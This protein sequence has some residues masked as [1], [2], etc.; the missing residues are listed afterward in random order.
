MT[1]QPLNGDV[2]AHDTLFRKDRA[3]HRYCIIKINLDYF[4]FSRFKMDL[5]W[6]DMRHDTEIHDVTGKALP[7]ISV[8]S[9][10]I[11]FLTDHLFQTLGD[12][13]HPMETSQILF[14]LTVPAIWTE[15]AKQ[16]MREAAVQAGIHT[17]QL[18][19]ALEPEAASLYCQRVPSQFMSCGTDDRINSPGTQY[20]VADIG[21]G[22][23][24]F[25]VHEVNEDGTLTEVHMATGG[26]YA[27]TN[28]DEEYIKLYNKIFG[29]KTMQKLKAMDMEEY[30]SISRNFET[31]KRLVCEEYSESFNV[32]L[33][34]ALFKRVKAKPRKMKK[35][36]AESGMKDLIS[37]DGDK[38]KFSP[39]AIK[40]LFCTPIDGIISHLQNLLQEHE[41]VKSILLVGGFSESKLLQEE[42]KKAMA[43]KTFVIPN[44]CGLAVLKGAVLYGHSPLSIT[45]R[46]MKY[47]YGVASDSIF[48]EGIHPKARKY[49]DENGEFRC[50]RS[51]SILI[52]KGTKVSATGVKIIRT[53]E[54]VTTTQMMIAERVYYT[55]NEN[56]IVVDE[57]CK[58]LKGYKL[59][60]PENN[61]KPRIV[62]STF[63][64]GLTEMKYCS[65]VIET[66]VQKVGTL[67]LL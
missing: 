6:K 41:K 22:T 49:K 66:G 5:H 45:S 31:K 60:L 59:S 52:S 26:P 15:S 56:P 27:G 1:S 38:I 23:A 47:T 8:F 48:K 13:G 25:S 62:K 9:S 63:T 16:F 10:S 40:R 46:I 61:G 43:D 57:K 21:G 55:D 67:D 18:V 19:L 37:I 4:F 42:I 28:V 64:F 34:A 2:I 7:A 17:N 20:L 24:D 29:W 3:Y 30:L 12:R 35:S 11:K 32:K 54:P 14:V 65:E 53:S 50:K 58:L 36:I 44:E 33:A 39:S 51:F